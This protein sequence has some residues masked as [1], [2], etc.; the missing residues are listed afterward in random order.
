M[1]QNIPVSWT[2]TVL[3]GPMSLDEEGEKRKLHEPWSDGFLWV[4]N[5]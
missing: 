1:A 4:N 3:M 5:V 2:F